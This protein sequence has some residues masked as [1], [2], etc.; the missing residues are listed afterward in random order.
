MKLLGNMVRYGLV[1]AVV[2]A[3]V[4]FL[5]RFVVSVVASDPIMLGMNASTERG[6]CPGTPNCVSSYAT[7]EDH[8][9]EP[10]AC[11]APGDIAIAAF[12]DA[13]DTLPDVERRGDTAWVVY[14]RIFRFPDDVTIDI[15]DRGIE[16]YSAS[17]LGS[18]DLGVNRRRVEMLR[19]LLE[20][21]PRCAV[22]G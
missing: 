20:D 1:A 14:S 6:G 13:I 19:D 22:S 16:V 15:S 9:I 4:F 21:D 10:I 7:T 5:G 12:A 2:C 3:G 17:R 11:P 8:A 18:G